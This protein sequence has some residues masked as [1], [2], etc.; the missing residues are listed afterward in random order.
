VGFRFPLDWEQR[1]HEHS[2]Y[3][4]KCAKREPTIVKQ[5]GVRLSRW[6]LSLLDQPVEVDGV[7]HRLWRQR[8][9]HKRLSLGLG[10]GMLYFCGLSGVYL[11][12][13]A[14]GTRAIDVAL[15][16]NLVTALS[17]VTWLGWLQTPVGVR[18]SALA[19]LGLSWSITI[20]TNVPSFLG[21]VVIPDLKGWTITFFAQATIIPFCW[22]LHW[23]SHLGAYAFFFMAS[24]LVHHRFTPID[25]SIDLL[26]DMAAISAMSTLVV[27]LY[28]RLSKVE[29]ETRQKLR[30]EQKRSEQLLLNV[31]PAS[32][33]QRLLHHHQTIADN[34]AEVS[35]LFT[36]I[37]GF[38]QLSSQMAPAEVVELLNQV[39]SRFDEL[40]ETYGLEK[41][42]TIGD[43]YMVVAGLPDH[44][45]DH[46]GAIVEMALAMQQ[47]LAVVNQQTGYSLQMRTGIHTGPVVA[48]VIGLK[49]FAYDLWGDTVNVASRMESHGLP[50]EIQVSQSTYDC[51][52]HHY[53]F[54]EREKLLIKGKG[55][56][57]TYLV[58][59]KLKV[60]DLV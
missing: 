43:A 28:E 7:S 49:K 41:I 23:V 42:K 52:R 56:M 55:E 4:E 32:I 39:F 26:F 24:W 18:Y 45:E 30:L 59:G 6:L 2:E 25:G 11:I 46:A 54:E 50:G 31:L 15:L 36:D 8:F 9:L 5:R 37:V 20:L 51:L 22:P 47:S 12:Q 27:Y 13:I 14:L 57:T 1:C 17:M 21:G 38:T 58:R 16:K 10:L 33:A 44:R 29:F 53:L 19:F 40:A 48:G 35:V 34:F 60:Q 3:W